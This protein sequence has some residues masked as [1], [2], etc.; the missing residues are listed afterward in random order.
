MSLVK[1]S[2]SK[3]TDVESAYAGQEF[4]HVDEFDPST[5]GQTITVERPVTAVA[6]KKKKSRKDKK[7]KRKVL[8]SEVDADGEEV[9]GEEPMVEAP[10]GDN[11]P[12]IDMTQWSEFNLDPSLVLGLRDLGFTAPTEIQKRTLPVILP[13]D[14][15]LL[16]AGKSISA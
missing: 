10:A 9:E 12:A 15:D 1:V 4:I 7:R 11:T 14:R 2:D 5:T 13:M 3:I 8:T 16:G 6:T